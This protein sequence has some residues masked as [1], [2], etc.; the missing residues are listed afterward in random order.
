MARYIPNYPISGDATTAQLRAELDGI[1]TAIDTLLSRLDTDNN[2]MGS[3]LDMNGFSIINGNADI[4]ELTS[5]ATIEIVNQIVAGTV[6]QF[7]IPIIDVTASFTPT[8]LQNNS[9]WVANSASAITMTVPPAVDEAFPI[10]S[11][12]TMATKGSGACAFVA[13]A[14]VTLISENAGLTLTQQNAVGSALL[15]AADTWLVTG[16]LTA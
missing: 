14:G 16:S 7:L 4:S 12:L 3:V 15:I 11:L 5:F 1:A 13:G 2:A 8:L 10:G 6:A 9:T